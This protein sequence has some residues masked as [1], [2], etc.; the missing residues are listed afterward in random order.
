MRP[1]ARAVLADA[2]LALALAVLGVV[3][4]P[5]I[6]YWQQGTSAI[7]APGFALIVAAALPL[8]ARRARPLVTLAL[9][10]AATSAYLV[11]SY[12]YGPILLALMIAVYTAASRLPARE[13]TAACAVALGVLLAHIVVRMAGPAGA[14]ALVGVVPGSAWVI[15]PYALGRTVLLSRETAARTRAEEVERHTYQERL[16]VAQE[17]HD[18]VGHGL[19]AIHMQAEIA[20]HLL[21][22]RPGQAET[23]LVAISRT[24]KEAL[25]ELRATL[26]VVRQGADAGGRGP[27][28]GLA[29]L[30]DL[31]ARMA[32]AG[33]RVAVTTQGAPRELPP[34]VDLAAYRV[35][36][37]SLTNV[38]R[39]AGTDAASVRLAYGASELTVEVTDAGRGGAGSGSGSGI[40]GMRER[41]TA[42][43]GRFEAGPR[44]GA[45]FRVHAR[46]PMAEVP[47]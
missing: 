4:T 43:G 9:T 25:D 3:V 16:R 13:A 18:V 45:G 7:G 21:A 41:V 44:P 47:R 27:V 46:L 20:L 42:L 34:A 35:V 1:W 26:A 32:A 17:V 10:T 37:E 15:V 5:R 28:P 29:R 22:R 24:S 31:A 6:G 14:E 39:H 36:Q 11:L 30:D 12:P 2:G 38:M 8:A 19:A 23:A 33:V 40:S